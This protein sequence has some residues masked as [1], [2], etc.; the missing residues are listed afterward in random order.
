MRG[1]EGM[2]MVIIPVGKTIIGKYRT[3][4]E[5]IRI[6]RGMKRVTGI[7]AFHLWPSVNNL[8]LVQ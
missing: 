2:E 5:M 4:S 6:K 8:E 3:P 7:G 1:S